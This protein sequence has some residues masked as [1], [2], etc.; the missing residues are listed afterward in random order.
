MHVVAVFGNEVWA[1]GENQR[2]FHSSDDGASW[3]SVTLPAKGSGEHTITHI[4]FGTPQDGKVEAEDG[5][6]WITTDGGKT[7]K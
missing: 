4:R 1:G 6:S 7:W 5:S 3:N 2:L